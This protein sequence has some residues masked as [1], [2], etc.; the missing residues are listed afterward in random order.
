MEKKKL[1]SAWSG[2]KKAWS[3][4][5]DNAS[6]G[7]AIKAS[8]S[9]FMIII[10]LMIPV[11][12]VFGLVGAGGKDTV[13]YEVNSS[14]SMD[15]S[16]YP[17]TAQV[18][19]PIPANPFPSIVA[20]VLSLLLSS[21]SAVIFIL[22]SL[23]VHKKDFSSIKE[24][25]TQAIKK[26]PKFIGMS[27]VYNL[28]VGVGFVLLIVPGIMLMIKLMF[29][30]FILVSE[31]TGIK[32]AFKRSGELTKG[33]RSALFGRLLTISLLYLVFFIPLFFLLFGLGMS[34]IPLL[35]ILIGLVNLNFYDDLVSMKVAKENLSDVSVIDNPNS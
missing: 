3:E 21:V 25:L 17:Q 19:T 16:G 1:T 5:T 11:F 6:L 32:E 24:L 7:F 23:S 8:V 29:A 15:Y 9:T 13:P 27:L 10:A 31:N 33:Y 12:V 22:I 28:I 2:I 18:A 4:L 14:I 30:P 26:A 34:I 35:T 20:N